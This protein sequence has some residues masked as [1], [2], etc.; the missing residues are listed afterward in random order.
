MN[1]VETFFSK[2]ASDPRRIVFPAGDDPRILGAAVRAAEL[3]IAVP[4]VLGA[5]EVIQASAEQAGVSA[6]AVETVNPKEDQRF[7]LF[8]RQYAD[9]RGVKQSI[10]E[11]LV[12]RPLMF[13]GMMVR[14]GD[15]DGMVAGSQHATASVI[16]AASL[17]IGLT[18]NVSTPTS[19][20]VMILPEWEG[21]KDKIFIFADSAVNVNPS[22]RELAESAVAAGADAAHLTGIEP[23]VALLSCSTKGSASHPDID[24]VTEALEIVRKLDPPFPVD[25]EL[26]ADAAIVPRVGAKKAPDSPV[27]GRATVLIFPDLDAGNIC[28][29]LV[30]YMGGATALGPVLV[31]FNRPVNDLSRGAVVDDIVGMTAITVLQAQEA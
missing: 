25:G 2:A 11:K 8:A 17:T 24:K 22:A 15:A 9:M 16:Q 13:G 5:P 18:E 1:L 31:G 19:Y 20:F 6:G 27:A 28:Y 7:G 4:V 12:K 26:Q 3:G 23:V 29:K 14:A 30:Q 10:A 21:E